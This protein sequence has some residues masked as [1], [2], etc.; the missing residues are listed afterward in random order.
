MFNKRTYQKILLLVCL[1][2]AGGLFFFRKDSGVVHTFRYISP[3]PP[4]V[5]KANTAAQEVLLFDMQPII[6]RVEKF[7]GKKHLAQN[8]YYLEDTA[9][10]DWLALVRFS[11]IVKMTPSGTVKWIKAGN[12]HHDIAVNATDDSFYTF[13]RKLQ[14]EVV[15]GVEIQ[16]KVDD[17]VQLD[18]HGNELRRIELYPLLESFIHRHQ[19]IKA[20]DNQDAENLKIEKDDKLDVMH[21]N[22]IELLTRRLPGVADS[23]DI[24]IS[25]PRFNFL[26]II[27]P[28]TASLVWDF[29]RKVNYWQHDASITQDNRIM[30]LDNLFDKSLG[31]SRLAKIDPGTKEV[32]WSFVK[33]GLYSETGG[34]AVE[35]DHGS[36]LITYA[37]IKTIVEVTHG[38]E[39]LSI[40]KVAQ[41]KLFG[42]NKIS[43]IKL[44]DST[45]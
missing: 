11:A 19:L 1:L 8:F 2:C 37:E 18:T 26:G 6:Q 5:I 30:V 16:L 29:K 40:T 44:L 41:N 13:E 3:N 39:I 25:C 27:N 14:T 38:G 34:G 43:K 15:N 28:D 22:S 31:L 32:V 45:D 17:I 23:G 12:F 21:C 4:L 20:A 42:D 9:S 35:T 10:A 36:I 7:T 24:L 33:E